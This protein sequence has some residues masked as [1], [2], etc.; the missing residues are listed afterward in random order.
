MQRQLD[1]VAIFSIRYRYR[2]R[3]TA[4]GRGAAARRPAHGRGLANPRRHQVD[5]QQLEVWPTLDARSAPPLRG[6]VCT[7]THALPCTRSAS[8]GHR[9]PP[10]PHSRAPRRLTGLHPVDARQLDGTR[11]TASA[12]L[13][14]VDGQRHARRTTPVAPRSAP[15]SMRPVPMGCLAPDRPAAATVCA[16]RPAHGTRST[17]RR[18]AAVR[19]I[20]SSA[21]PDTGQYRQHCA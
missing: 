6:R 19:H 14:P 21:R 20:G 9:S 8:S 10:T 16:L 2:R 15:I 5:A 1:T 18:H 17:P 3:S 11:S 4:P 12:G 7:A 13:H